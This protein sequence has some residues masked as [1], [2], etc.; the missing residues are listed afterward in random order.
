MS[1]DS[2]PQVVHESPRDYGE[3]D[4]WGNSIGSLRLNLKLTPL[5]RLRKAEAASRS[6]HNLKHA[7]KGADTV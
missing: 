3:Q 6:L 5:E 4:A 1:D 7:I 2:E